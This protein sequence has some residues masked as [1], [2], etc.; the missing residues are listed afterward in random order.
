MWEAEKERR[1]CAH[2]IRQFRRCMK[3]AGNPGRRVAPYAKKGILAN[4]IGVGTHWEI[5]RDHKRHTFVLIIDFWG[6]SWSLKA[7]REESLAAYLF[8]NQPLNR[9]PDEH[10]IEEHMYYD[11]ASIA[12]LVQDMLTA[13]LLD[14]KVSLP[15]D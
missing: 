15:S 11:T 8:S 3:N 1:R 4:L 10:I 13:K 9:T 5:Y 12:E 6:D 14:N 7:N 2:F